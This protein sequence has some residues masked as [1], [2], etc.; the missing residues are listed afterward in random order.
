MRTIAPAALAEMLKPQ[1]GHA[2]IPLVKIDHSTLSTPFYFAANYQ[3]ITFNSIVYKA[4]P[5]DLVLPD[6]TDEA[7]PQVKLVLDNVGQDLVDLIRTAASS[8]TAQVYVVSVDP[9]N[10]ATAI[11]G[12]LDFSVVGVSYTIA[13]VEMTL[14]FKEDILNAPATKDMFDPTVAPGLF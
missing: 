10:V 6:D 4:F 12:P 13:T 2:V 14:A 9:S 7:P 5:F 11:V 1:T 8:L 3:D